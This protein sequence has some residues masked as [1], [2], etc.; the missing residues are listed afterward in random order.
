L[1]TDYS[2]NDVSGSIINVVKYQN[3]N[4]SVF[5]ESGDRKITVTSFPTEKY[6]ELIKKLLEK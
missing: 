2:F 5:L 4:V 3:G 1:E 6:D